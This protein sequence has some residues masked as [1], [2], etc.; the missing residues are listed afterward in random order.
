M[1]LHYCE[2]VLALGDKAVRA[3]MGTKYKFAG[4]QPATVSHR[5]Q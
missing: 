3:V 5:L 2:T 4:A 1:S